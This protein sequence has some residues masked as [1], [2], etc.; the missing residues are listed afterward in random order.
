MIKT[1][2]E[3]EI[4]KLLSFTHPRSIRDYTMIL[5]ALMTGLRVSEIVGLY[6]EDL[7]ARTEKKGKFQ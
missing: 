6:I 7:S 5:L 2:S 1:I 4:N 3:T